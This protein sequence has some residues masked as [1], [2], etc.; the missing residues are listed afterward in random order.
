MKQLDF[1]IDSLTPHY[2]EYLNNKSRR[3]YLTLRANRLMTDSIPDGNLNPNIISNFDGD[4]RLTVLDNAIVLAQSNLDN[5]NSYRDLAIGKQRIINAYETEYHK[6]LAFS[7]ACLVLFFI[8]A[9]LGSIIRKGGFGLPMIIAIVIF[10]IYFFLSTLGKNMAESNKISPFVGGWLATFVL[11]PFGLLLL[12]RA[13]NDKG[14]F[15]MERFLSPIN[16]LI[17]RFKKTDQE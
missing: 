7:V 14:L 6:R 15:S 5:L 12:K 3:F 2:Q 17:R 8:G 4:K 11:L 9:P 1:Y 16:Q 13:T 10:V